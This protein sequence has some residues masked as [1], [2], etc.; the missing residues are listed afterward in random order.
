[1]EA[2]GAGKASCWEGRDEVRDHTDHKSHR[3]QRAGEL[4]RRGGTQS[5]WCFDRILLLLWGHY[6]LGRGRTSPG[7]LSMCPLSRPE[8][9]QARALCLGEQSTARVG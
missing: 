2:G 8:P 6:S 4:P 9:Q 3:S 1:M 7:S 5:D